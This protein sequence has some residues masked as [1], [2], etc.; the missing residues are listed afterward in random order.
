MTTETV[1]RGSAWAPLRRPLFRAIWGS[2][3]GS[4]L[5]IWMHNVGAVTVVASLTDSP[6]LIA[7]VQTATSAPAA[8]TATR[9]TPSS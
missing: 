5:V 8:P 6:A 4:Q 3:L 7:A 9:P 1:Q 2:L